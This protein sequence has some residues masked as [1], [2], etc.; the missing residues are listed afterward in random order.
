MKTLTP[1]AVALLA[2]YAAAILA[3]NWLIAR[4]GLVPVGFGLVAPAGVYAAGLVLA[5]RDALHERAGRGWVLA[6]V[7]AGAAFSGLL[8]GPL[9]LASGAAFLV[10]ELADWLV[11]ARLRGRDGRGWALALVGSNAVGALADS[12]LFLMLAFGSL[13]FLAGQLVGKG[14]A[15]LAA[16]LL[17]LAWR[18]ALPPYKPAPVVL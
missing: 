3:A 8:S 5:L 4:F 13:D 17:A 10:S 2:L 6:A 9:A 18:R 14:Y 7:V 11:Y 16:L 15:T 1:A 12:A